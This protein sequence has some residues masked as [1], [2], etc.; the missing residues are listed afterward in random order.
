MTVG[1]SLVSLEQLDALS[2]Y[3]DGK[4]LQIAEGVGSGSVA[5]EPYYKGPSDN[6]CLFCDFAAACHFSVEDGDRRRF[7]AKAGDTGRVG[8]NHRGGAAMSAGSIGYT[9]AQLAAIKVRGSSLLVS[10]G[11]GSGKTRVLVER[12]LEYIAGEDA[13]DITDFL[14]I[15]YTRAA[16]EELRSRIL[17]AISE[18]PG[19]GAGQQASPAS[20]GTLHGCNHRHHPTASAQNSYAKTRILPVCRRISASPTRTSRPLLK[21]Q[22]LEDLL[23]ARY[24]ALDAAPDFALLVDTMSAGRDD[25]KLRQIVLEAHAKLQSHADPE[26][27][28]LGQIAALGAEAP[29]DASETVW[30]AFLMD[31]ARKKSVYWL[32]VLCGLAEEIAGYPDLEKAYGASIGA[33]CAGL[34]GFVAALGRSWDEA[35]AGADIPFPKAKA[36]S[37]YDD[38]KE[39]RTKCRNA[40]RK[41]ADLFRYTSKDLL[42]DMASATPAVTALLELVQQFDRA[43]ALAKRKASLADFSDLEHLTARLLVDFGTSERTDTA[44]AVA[45][46][47]REILIDEYQDVSRVQEL[48]F[49]AVSNNG[50]NIFM[51]G[52]VK[53][54]IYR[55]RLAD[56]TIF[57]EKYKTYADVDLDL[58]SADTDEA[59]DG[60]KG[61]RVLLS[62]NFRSRAGILDAVNFIFR[63]V[64]SEEFGEMSYTEK[65][66]LIPGRTDTAVEDKW[67]AAVEIDILDLSGIETPEDEENPEK[68]AVEGRLR[69]GADR[70]ASERGAAYPGRQRRDA[71]GGTGRY[72][73]SAALSARQG[74][75]L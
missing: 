21:E 53:Q 42:E 36:I 67:D 3:I 14:V 25:G 46:R 60:G 16:A 74:R 41:V 32:R 72:R 19:Y 29:R 70:G 63:N 1:E 58:D 39:Q 48:I 2:R 27:W 34:E 47:Y 62:E 20:G 55:F 57:L 22:I 38:L 10:A 7:Y 45:R 18:R 68:T 8:K 13:C 49:G 35:A 5:A 71:P 73:H 6:A 59:A 56:P 30:G 28:I 24:E 43:Y 75:R 15:T 64:M 40:I 26:A 37:G 33:S 66:C 12:L 11:A 9:R 69:C 61:R 31:D 54:S 17:E 4:L 52:D 51:V 50:E 44:K 23:D 65:E